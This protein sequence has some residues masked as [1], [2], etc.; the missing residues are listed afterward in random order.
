VNTIKD[1]YSRTFKTLRISLTNTCNFGC[2]YCVH[3]ESKNTELKP[4][5][6]LL[7]YKEIAYIASQIHKQTPLKTI[8]LTGGEPTL[9]KD[10]I[11]ITSELKSIG[12]ENIKMTTNG[13]LLKDKI[14]ALAQAGLSH[15]NISFDA[16]DKQTFQQLSGKDGERN[17]RE[18]IDECVENG[19]K[20]KINSVI[21]KGINDHQI[22]PLFRFS[23][24]RN[25]PIRFLELMRM[26][27]LHQSEKFEAY[28]FSEE[29]ILQ[30]IATE[31]NYQKVL[32]QH[33]STANYWQTSDGYT[34]GIIA[35]ESTPFCSDCDRLRLDSYGNIYGCLS[36][37]NAISI[38]G[39]INNEKLLIEKLETALQQKQPVRFKGSDISMMAI[40]G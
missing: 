37:N 2:V 33:S 7:D 8:R 24:E 21:L 12:I 23:K 36:E 39:I 13:Y 20:V 34:F 31:Y 25:I 22:L 19:V 26:G 17:V 10:L 6:S 3:S 1:Q 38:S 32:R 35:N 11:P 18:S 4:Q 14:K 30:E 28:F 15:I 16:S 5:K 40:G 27:P 29:E 9:Y